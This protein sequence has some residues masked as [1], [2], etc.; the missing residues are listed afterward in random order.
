MNKYI[1]SAMAVVLPALLLAQEQQAV[2]L[3]NTEKGTFQVKVEQFADLSILRYQIGGWDM[4][5]TD[6]K[7]LVYY[8]TEAGYAGRDIIYDQNYKY[9]LSIRHALEHIVAN[10]HGARSGKDWDAFMVYTK[11]VWFSNGIHHHYSMD[12]IQPGFSQDYFEFLMMSYISNTLTFN[13]NYSIF[14]D[15]NSNL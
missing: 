15:T 7:K 1:L 2:G 9:N 13:K 3:E 6:Q 14:I 5:S 10:Y 11:R 4:L 12:K 8:L